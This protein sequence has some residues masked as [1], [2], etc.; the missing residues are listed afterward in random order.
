MEARGIDL[1]SLAERSGVPYNTL[2]EL[3][4]R[5]KGGSV[6][7]WER[8]AQYFAVGVSYL[9]GEGASALNPC[10]FKVV[11]TVGAT[12]GRVGAFSDEGGQVI[13]IPQSWPVLS[14]GSLASTRRSSA[15]SRAHSS[16]STRA[17]S[18]SMSGPGTSAA[19]AAG[20]R[21][22]KASCLAPPSLPRERLISSM[23]RSRIACR[24]SRRRAV[25]RNPVRWPTR[26]NVSSATARRS[27]SMC[28]PI[29]RQNCMAT[30]RHQPSSR[31]PKTSAA[32][33]GGEAG[34]ETAG[35]AGFSRAGPP[36]LGSLS[37]VRKPVQLLP[38]SRR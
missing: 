7:V 32:A 18:G 34:P 25:P 22:E 11:G 2:R 31:G 36:P 13:E 9:R 15:R 27:S 33:L 35:Q 38:S 1:A 24:A 37:L 29:P 3:G 23:Q 16:R 21:R 10:Q 8:L 30:A 26:Q 17:E 28:A 20:A 19:A 12:R 6:H 14:T 5:E 4:I